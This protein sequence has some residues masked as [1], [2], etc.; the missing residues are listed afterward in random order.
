MTA[1]L[2]W[3]EGEKH[4]IH[5]LSLKHLPPFLSWFHF[6]P[7]VPYMLFSSSCSSS[8]LP[9]FLSLSLQSPVC[10]PTLNNHAIASDPLLPPFHPSVNHAASCLLS[11]SCLVSHGLIFCVGM[12]STSQVMEPLRSNS[13]LKT[14]LSVWEPS[15]PAPASVCVCSV[16]FTFSVY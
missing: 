1:S 7:L 15:Q 5:C 4:I 13:F 3:F 2:F 14:R 10:L 9:S 11:F 12:W 16:S 8:M 6:L